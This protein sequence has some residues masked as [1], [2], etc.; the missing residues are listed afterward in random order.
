[1]PETSR[2]DQQKLS[3][4]QPWVAECSWKEQSILFS[5][6]RGPDHAYLPAIKQVS[7]WMRSMCQ[8]NADPTKPYMNEIELPEPYILEKEL[9]H[10]FAHFVHHFAD[11]LAVIAYNHPDEWVRSKAYSYHYYIAEELFHFIPEPPEVFKWRHRD[12]PDGTDP[13]PEKPLDDREWVHT[14]LPPGF[15]HDHA[16]ARATS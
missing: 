13:Q 12:K 2:P 8:H 1:M 10:S 15:V 11:A 7:K 16:Q 9:E 5:G 14:L 4:V 3:V 6:L